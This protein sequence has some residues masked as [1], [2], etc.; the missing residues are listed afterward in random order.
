[1]LCFS[2]F[3]FLIPPRNRTTKPKAQPNF[4]TSTNPTETQQSQALY[5]MS[6]NFHLLIIINK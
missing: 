4:Q 2:I 3:F 1:M 6:A 5:L